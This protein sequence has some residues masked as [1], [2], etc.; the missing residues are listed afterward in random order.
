MICTRGNKMD[1]DNWEV[2]GN[3]GWSYQDLLP[4]FLK[5]EDANVAVND[6]EYRAKGGP[7]GV[8]DVY[9]TT[10]LG[11]VF[12]EAAQQAGYPYVDY[13]GRQQMGV[14][15]IQGTL[16]NGLR[17]DA[18]NS[19]LRSVRH[20]KNLKIRTEAHV[21]KI[22]MTDSKEAYG[23]E[24]SK[25]GRMYT[26]LAKKEVILS[27]GGL[28][29][30]QILML[31]GI[32]PR[33]QLQE[34][35]IPVIEDLAVGTIMYDHL[36]FLGAAFLINQPVGLQVLDYALD[37]Q[38]YVDFMLHRRGPIT[39]F[40]LEVIAFLK[41]NLTEQNYPAWPDIE[42]LL[43]PG[44]LS[45]DFGIF[46]KQIFNIDD[47]IYNS[48]WKPITGK[49]V[50]TVLP[51]LLQPLSKGN[52]RLRSKNP[53]D[54]GKYTENYFSDPENLDIKRM[55]AGIREIQRIASQPALKK[56]EPRLVTTPF[57]GCNRFTFDSDAYWECAIRAIPAS[58]YHQ[59]STC[60]MGPRTNKEAVV[61][62]RL[63]V[64]GIRNLRVADISIFPRPTSG[65]TVCPAYAIGE[66]AADLIK[67]DWKAA[68]TE[69]N[70]D[71]P[72]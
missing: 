15:R 72:Y 40:A 7:L 59:Q 23:V 62:A 68:S 36:T 37:P 48:Y 35:D 12:M 49:P 63:R 67:E 52:V 8:S 20:R 19:Y 69:D 56:F 44:H 26:V 55:I 70:L 16:R 45:T 6:S 46:F 47:E 31:S 65:H 64:H 10:K 32:G 5:M 60:R 24:Y 25:D 34:F 1:Y 4:Y 13:N 41:T 9:F 61:D 29:S 71:D 11:D 58:I 18:E 39:S 17:S 27:A 50:F 2:M 30:P 54:T 3:P 33:S 38:T 51:V 22:L 21:T 66:K 14:S 53:F 42:L 28:N 43:V 57:P